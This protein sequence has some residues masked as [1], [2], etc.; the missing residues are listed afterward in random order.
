MGDLRFSDAVVN[1]GFITAAI[2][3]TSTGGLRNT[4]TRFYLMKGTPPNQSELNAATNNFRSTDRLIA[5]IPYNYTTASGNIITL[6]FIS[7]P[8]AATGTAT[9]W[10]WDAEPSQASATVATIRM[11][12]TVTTNGGGGD[13]TMASVDVVSGE[14]VGVGVI[15]LEILQSYTY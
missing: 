13:L 3:H 11:S 9:W 5:L 14:T 12:G 15:N 8:A 1:A 7:G 6:D 10:Y 2:N 4:S